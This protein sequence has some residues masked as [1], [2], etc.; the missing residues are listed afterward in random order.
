MRFSPEERACA[1]IELLHKKRKEFQ[2]TS[3]LLA[4]W[5]L[6]QKY[7]SDDPI[8]LNLEAR[9]EKGEFANN[10]ED[11]YQISTNRGSEEVEERKC[12]TTE[13]FHHF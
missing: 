12:L 9:E 10:P 13:R 2:S 7:E 8:E 6:H 3:R 1:E 5:Q 4:A 11:H